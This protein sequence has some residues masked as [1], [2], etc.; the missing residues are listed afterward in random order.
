MAPAWVLLDRKV[1]FYPDK[2]V[3]AGETEGDSEPV[4]CAIL[5]GKGRPSEQEYVDAIT[6]YLRSLKPDLF[7]ADPPE[8][9][10]LRMLRPTMST[11]PLCDRVDSACIS[12]ADKHLAALYAGHYRP[13]NVNRG[14]Y[15]IYDARK[16]SLST[17]PHLPFEFDDSQ[18][19]MGRH[20]AVVVCD[21]DGD[22]Y[23]LAELV[24]VESV[25][26]RNII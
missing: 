25:E 17:I 13:G 14:C 7:L 22:G 12:S 24:R 6:A 5:K 3:F 16:N 2:T 26:L 21:G 9:S 1:L 18:E 20:T 19:N 4:A 15:L 10:S 8:L 23:T 11:P